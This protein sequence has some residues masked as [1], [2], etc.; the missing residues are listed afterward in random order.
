MRHL[1]LKT[2]AAIV[3]VATFL[4]GCG[5]SK[6]VKK[7][8]TVKYTVTPEV[9]ETLGG[10]ISVTVKGTFPAKY[11]SK[12][13][14]VDFAPVLTYSGG[15]TPLKSVTLQGEKVKGGTGTVI[16]KK[17]GGA[18]SYSDVITYD[19]K[20]NASELKVTVVAK[21]KKKT[22]TLAERKLADGVIYTSERVTR[23]EDLTLAEHG[24]Q[25]EVII[26]KA[27]TVF[28]AYN[29]SDLD[30][31][32][33]L[34]KDN[35][36][37]FKEFTDFLA[38]QWKI[39]NIDVSAWASP[40]GEENYNRDLSDKRGK[41]GEKYLRDMFAKF[42]AD[43]NKKAGIKVDPKSKDP[44]PEDQISVSVNAKG[45]DLEGFTKAI[46][47]SDIK[48][49]NTILN[50]VNSQNDMV[51]RQEEINKM[52][53]IY[54]EVEDV[55][56]P[57]LRRA[58][59]NVNCFEP[60]KTDER[61]A[62]LATTQPDSL[63][64][65]ELLYAATLTQDVNT[66][67]KI[68]KSATTQFAQD[69]RGYNNAGWALLKLNNPEEAATYL[70]KANTLSPN[71]GIVINNL[72]V[73]ASWKKDYD[74][75]KSYYEQAQGKGIAE[76]YNLG[77]IMIR[78]GEFANALTSF[79]SKTC[80]HNIALAQLLSGNAASS[81][82]TLEC[83]KKDGAVYYLLAVVG[84]RTGNTNLMYDNLKKACQENADYKAQ[85]KEDREFLKYFGK[86]DFTSAIQ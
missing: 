30:F 69:W 68:Y 32:L 40:E 73:V 53:V 23:D 27:G 49:K 33:K 64:N 66:Q 57:P 50:V 11:F 58:E 86:S 17:A 74:N 26:S 16:A 61:I 28:F 47:N 52:A 56:L 60:K 37:T 12:K 59:M 65:K 70:D 45:E 15:S 84:A 77:I 76:G 31:K 3:L 7:Y 35:E 2:L 48:E 55:I 21:Q 46:S 39:K 41:T 9:L 82:T 83:S 79:G 72:G 20:M 62:Q 10:K 51:K 81:A 8:E 63:D 4:S 18:F 5:L 25:K 43:A 42:I 85:A 38:K 36:V 67:L 71:N 75:A 44:K 6:M 80:T 24:Y 22:A 19:P 1:N 13:A 14:T 78:K 54:K 34:N 29:K